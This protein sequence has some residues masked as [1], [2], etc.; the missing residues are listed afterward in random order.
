MSDPLSR[1]VA[2]T[3]FLILPLSAAAG[4]ALQLQ[5]AAR[6]EVANDEMVVSLAA[7]RRGPEVGPLNTAVLSQLNAAIVQAKSMPGIEARLGGVMTQPNWSDNRQDGWLVRGEVI[8]DSTNREALAKLAGRL[9]KTLQ[10]AGVQ[11]RLSSMRRV[12]EENALIEEAAGN[13]RSKADAAA[14]AFGFS[15]YTLRELS[16]QPQNGMPPPFQPMTS[17]R[18]ATAEAVPV[19][20]EGGRSE[21]VVTVS[22][23]VELQ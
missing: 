18:A 3:L 8:L 19:P 6:S 20:V 5:A 7:E 13:F 10:L 22:G 23:T 15:G 9:A 16:L 17:M 4:P 2:A 12:Q 14:K 21:I 1:V 11:F